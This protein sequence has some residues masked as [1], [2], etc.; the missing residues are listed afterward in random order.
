MHHLIGLRIVG[1]NGVEGE[2]L[3]AVGTEFEAILEGRHHA[4]T[5]EINLHDSEVLA[6]VLVPLDHYAIRH[7]GR[8]ERHDLVESPTA[9]HH[10]AGVLAEMAGQAVELLMESREGS[11]SGVGSRQPR[12]GKLLLEFDRVREVSTVKESG[13]SPHD[14]VGEPEH[15]T[16]FAS[17]PTTTVG[18]DVGGHS[19]AV[20]RVASVDFLDDGFT[21]STAGQVQIYVGP[22]RT[23]AG[24]DA[25]FAEEAFEEEVVLHGVDGGDAQGIADDAVGCGAS[26]LH[27]NAMGTG[28]LAE[29][30]HDQEVAAKPEP[31]DEGEFGV[32]L[33]AVTSRDA[34]D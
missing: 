21:E 9:N 14:V 7:G 13:E 23:T 8:L 22:R 4:E 24:A 20:R 31:I 2:F 34:G 30:G 27:E 16:E 25:A 19:R 26:A 15:F 18:D 29:V 11:G 32:D 10:A 17:G 28:P 33:A 3:A 5:E 1:G 12:F 6:V